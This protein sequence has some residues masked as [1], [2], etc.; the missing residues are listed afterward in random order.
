MVYPVFMA[1]H[2]YKYTYNY[3]FAESKLDIDPGIVNRNDT[4]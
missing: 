4:S 2:W 3:Y 1:I